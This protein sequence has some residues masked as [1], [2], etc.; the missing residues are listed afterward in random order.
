LSLK[1]IITTFHKGLQE[2]E[3][4]HEE[5]LSASRKIVILSKQAVMAIHRSQLEEARS[6]LEQ[7]KETIEQIEKI[8]VHHQDLITSSTRTA[9]QEYS[10]AQ[11]FL[12][13]VEK[14]KFPSPRELNVPII[15]YLLGLADSVG[16][17]RRRALDFLRKGKLKDA[18]NFL[19]IM[20]EVYAELITLDS[21]Y[22]VAP[23]LRR[24]CDIAR[25]VIEATM[26]DVATESRRL[27]LEKSI[28]LLEKKIGGKKVEVKLQRDFR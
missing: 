14:G 5:T 19:K 25:H 18:E 13:L 22:T 10:E 16:E 3:K 17:F 12:W 1:E 28:K 20:D 27:S 2:K 7:A 4:I 23:E 26:G 24:K 6:K 15:P 11:I 8:L 21:A 9:Y